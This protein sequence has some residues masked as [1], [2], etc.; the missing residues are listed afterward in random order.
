MAI[1]IF[2]I[3]TTDRFINKNDVEITTSGSTWQNIATLNIDREE[4]L[5][6]AQLS[7]VW[8]YNLT[9]K[10]GKFRWSVD[11]GTTW[12]ETSEEPKDKTDL[13]P[14]S[15]VFPVEHIGGG[16]RQIL[17]EATRENDTH[18]MTM[19]YTSVLFKRIGNL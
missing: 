13:R 19:K 18:T 11:G 3:L 15:I 9:N 7:M 10:S 5:Y 12:L 8:N 14:F 2:N 4:G 17:L 16:A 6:D 1:E